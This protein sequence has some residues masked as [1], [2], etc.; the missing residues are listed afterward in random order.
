MLSSLENN[1]KINKYLSGFTIPEALIMLLIATLVTVV[2]VPAITK[3]HKTA[4]VHGK[5]TCT[6]DKL[7]RHYVMT[8]YNGIES[9]FKATGN[10]CI[11]T[12]PANAK[13]FNVKAVAGG[14]GGAFGESGAEEVVYD[15]S[16][17]GETFVTAVKTDGYYT[18]S[19]TGA[20][21]GGGGMSCGEASDFVAKTNGYGQGINDFGGQTG[22]LNHDFTE[23]WN[24]T[25]QVYNQT[26][27]ARHIAAVKALFGR[28]MTQS[29]Y[30]SDIYLPMKYDYGYEDKPV[31]T[32]NYNA[33]VKNDKR[34]TQDRP[35]S[36]EKLRWTNEKNES[37]DEV[38]IYDFKYKY[39]DS[40][41]DL[42]L[43]NLCFATSNTPFSKMYKKDGET[44]YT[45]G[46]YL[47]YPKNENESVKLAC[48][49][50]PGEGGRAGSTDAKTNVFLSAGQNIIVNTGRGGKGVKDETSNIRNIGL[51][52]PESPN[53]TSPSTYSANLNGLAGT[54]GTDTTVIA[55]ANPQI[56]GTGGRGGVARVIK[57]I[58]YKNIPV[59]ECKIEYGDYA[60]PYP[61]RSDNPCSGRSGYR[62]G[63]SYCENVSGCSVSS[64]RPDFDY[65]YGGD[66]CSSHGSAS[67][68]SIA[69]YKETITDENGDTKEVPRNCKVQYKTWYTCAVGSHY[70]PG[71]YTGNVCRTVVRRSYFSVPVCISTAQADNLDSSL[72]EVDIPGFLYNAILYPALKRYWHG[73]DYQSE[74]LS[75]SYSGPV[76]HTGQNNFGSGGYGVGE[77]A[78]TYFE[79]VM[80]D[81]E[82]KFQPRFHGYDGQD[83]YATV[84]RISYSGGGGGQA[85]QYSSFILKK[86]GKLKVQIGKGGQPAGDGGNT[87]ITNYLTNDILISLTGGKA[88]LPKSTNAEYGNGY[89]M[90]VNGALSPFESPYN[91]AR[92]VPYGG[93]Q[94]NNNSYDGI[95]AGTPKW[96]GTNGTTGYLTMTYGAGGGGGAADKEK[97]G[98]GG[99]GVPGAVVIEW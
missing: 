4:E 17:D 98:M 74:E 63:D 59:R 78:K 22:A 56:T 53:S 12:P 66:G 24:V 34:F 81:A 88:G 26:C 82:H 27:V 19:A 8:E 31:T 40:P 83:G 41:D 79:H 48:W 67:S 77:S 13:T 43:R 44:D 11:F 57:H 91:K 30:A 64:R 2:A 28:D 62:G 29:D 20:G 39:L 76:Y 14:G 47:Q 7:G 71:F 45:K 36:T 92:I 89:M 80:T 42:M 58:S 37:Q 10:S 75:L 18:I 96:A 35:E 9:D 90:G 1:K 33:L 46:I 25:S 85:G 15:T 93:K 55:G 68:C 94:G 60:K 50:L 65:C 32:F 6:I 99:Y 51:F 86:T 21:G 87:I 97:F 16:S 72:S 84:K 70:G 38:S 23:C 5:W 73:D 3:K 61:N 54:N 69:T 49:N 52:K 95:S